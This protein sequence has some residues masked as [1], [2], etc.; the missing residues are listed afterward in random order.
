MRKGRSDYWDNKDPGIYVDVVSGEPLF[1]SVS[2]FDSHTGWPSFT[3]PIEPG[4]VVQR[5]DFR[6]LIPGPRS[7]PPTAAATSDS[8]SVT[9]PRKPEACA[10][11]SPRFTPA[12]DLERDGWM[13]PPTCAPPRSLTSKP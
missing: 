8:Y 10:T 3:V 5:R 11:A 1:A 4:N 6:M 2:K 13:N 7:V 9:G 12:G